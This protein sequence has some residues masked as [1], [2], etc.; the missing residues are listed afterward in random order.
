[1]KKRFL[2]WALLTALALFLLPGAALAADNSG[3]AVD[4]AR[5]GVARV[6][7][8]Y[9]CR[10]GEL[11]E[12]L[13]VRSFQSYFVGSAFGVGK[14]AGQ[15]ASYFVT[16]RHVVPVESS[17]RISARQ[18]RVL[19]DL[20]LG[21]SDDTVYTVPLS[22]I[23]VYLLLDDN[24][25]SSATGLD[26]SRAVPCTVVHRNGENEP[27]LAVLRT[28]EP[29]DKRVVLPLM[30]AEGENG[31]GG[32]GVSES[33]YALGFP[34]SADAAGVVRYENSDSQDVFFAGSVRSC[35]ATSGTVNRFIDY[36][37]ENCR[38][39]QHGAP[40]NPGN[41]GGPLVT[42]Q[43]AVVGVNTFAFNLN[44]VDNESQTNNYA[45]VET[46]YVIRMLN[47][48]EIPYALYSDSPA[49]DWTRWA[50]IGGAV[51]LA[52]VVIILIV[53]LASKNGRKKKDE[54]KNDGDFVP[55]PPPPSPAA[56]PS[57]R[58]MSQQHG[59]MQVPVD[60]QGILIGRS[61]SDC[62]IVFQSGTPGVS[63]RHCSVAWDEAAGEFLLT[64]LRST[65]GT[66]LS[67]GQKLT[68][69]VAA[70]LRP[71]DTFYLGERDNALRVELG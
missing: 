26:T 45:A 68:P 23:R 56:H 46:E 36:T 44:G 71:G 3:N 52:L 61:M 9:E 24:A 63:A 39:I 14:E 8:V 37:T 64:D 66:F 10:E 22:L 30:K 69:G 25:Y 13:S 16:N 6:L 49:V 50:V 11:G 4:E 62:K 15:P 67:N 54:T 12:Y 65:Y 60:S 28:E 42:Q 48:L 58:S 2:S 21:D 51:L 34:T 17:T 7:C 35:S 47:Q 5:S 33:V 43:G 53:V 27:D 29:V 20:D 31:Q 19:Y 40:I 38:V 70:R 1:M 57:V 55:P 32:V 18:L 59:G 41:S